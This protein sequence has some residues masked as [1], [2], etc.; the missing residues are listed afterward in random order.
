MFGL[1]C[2]LMHNKD[3]YIVTPVKGC[4]IDHCSMKLAG[5][6]NSLMLLALLR[7]RYC[8]SSKCD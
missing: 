4:V 8:M 7:T 6:R 3:G 2:S 1:K 5:T